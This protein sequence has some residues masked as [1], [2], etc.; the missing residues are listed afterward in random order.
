M[1]HQSQVGLSEAF[2]IG[3]EVATFRTPGEALATVRDLLADPDR[4]EAMAT[5]ALARMRRD[6]TW[7]VRLPQMLAAAGLDLASFRGGDQGSTAEDVED[8]C[9]AA[10]APVRGSVM[11]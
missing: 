7:D 3:S 4:R 8:A 9:A 2:E 5:R 10:S 6:H 11:P 1:L